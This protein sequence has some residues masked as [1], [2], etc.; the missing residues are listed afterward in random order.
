MLAEF[1]S[2]SE[3]KQRLLIDQSCPYPGQVA[4]GNFGKLLIQQICDDAVEHRVAQEFQTLV[5][6]DTVR[7]MGQ[8]LIQEAAVLKAMPD[9]LLDSASLHPG[10]R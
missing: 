7:P 9:L 8:S 5:M 1:Q 3:F 6:W 10:P 2:A 4:L